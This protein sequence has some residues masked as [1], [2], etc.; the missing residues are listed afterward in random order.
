MP[1][2][3]YLSLGTNL[4]DR[5]A[6]LQAAREGLAPAVRMAAE[7]TIYET[8]P[9]GYTD[10]PAF[11]NQAVQA[12]TE[13]SPRE[14]L[15]Y[16]KNLEHRMGREPSF[17]YGPRLIDI[18][19]LLYDNL[20]TSSPRITIPHPHLAERAFVL[21][22]LAELAPELDVP[23]LGKSVKELAAAVDASGVKPLL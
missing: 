3:I 9:W 6:N 10:Q 22:P 20:V 23:G 15:T 2:T 1:H 14:L 5:V 17:P 13:L 16:L 11:L 12:E 8:A 19:I 21:A 4:G 7:S 18:D